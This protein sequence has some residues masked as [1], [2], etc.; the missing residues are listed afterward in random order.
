[1]PNGPA[2]RTVNPVHAATHHSDRY[3]LLFSGITPNLP[4]KWRSQGSACDRA[5][6][7]VYD[8]DRVTAGNSL[9]PLSVEMAKAACSKEVANVNHSAR[10]D[11]EMGRTLL[12]DGD[13]QGARREFEIAMDRGYAA[14]RIDLA[15]MLLGRSE[16][17]RDTK[18]GVS[19]LE[20]AWADHVAIAADKLGSFY[21]YGVTV[22]ERVASAKATQDDARVMQWYQR[23]AAAD[24]P[25]A[26]AHLA[27]RAEFHS[28]NQSDATERN[29]DLLRAFQLYARA[30]KVAQSQGWPSE[31]WQHWR[32]RRASL[33]RLLANDG[34]MQRVATAYAAILRENQSL[35][36]AAH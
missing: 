35:S 10:I 16:S 12:A 20:R 27:E 36:V 31:A 14:A 7:A 23:G 21:E 28:L 22:P 13:M 9:A 17:L 8:P 24:E 4:A 25:Y 26:L 6:S 1:V 34:L 18:L 5:A 19:L 15:D 30:V 3:F 11:F 33:A 29:S 2:S 32:Y